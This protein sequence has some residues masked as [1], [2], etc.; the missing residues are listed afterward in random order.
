MP[1]AGSEFRIPVDT[2]VAAIGQALEEI[3]DE[4]VIV[5]LVRQLGSPEDDRRDCSV[6]ALGHIGARAVPALADAPAVMATALA[7]AVNSKV[8]D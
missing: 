2:V 7:P 5:A 4:S 1:I 6:S 3:A 8:P